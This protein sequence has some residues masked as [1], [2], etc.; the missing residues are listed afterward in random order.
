MK[1]LFIFLALMFIAYSA[2]AQFKVNAGYLNSKITFSE[3]GISASLKGNGFYAGVLYD[4]AVGDNGFSFE[5]GLNFDYINFEAG[6]E[7]SA[8]Y[9]LRAPLHFN[10]ALEV[11]DAAKLIFGAG[12]SLNVG[13]GGEDEPFG[14]GGFNRFDLHLGGLLGVRIGEHFEI[15]AGYDFGLLKAVDE[16]VKNHRNSVTVGLAYSF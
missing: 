5:P 15:R 1:K 7:S 2:S 3:S 10:Y 8:V 16:D 9:Y 13:L 11:S 6:G 14:D 12:P 4:V